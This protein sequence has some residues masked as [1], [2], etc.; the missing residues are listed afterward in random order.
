MWGDVKGSNQHWIV[1]QCTKIFFSLLITC[2]QILWWLKKILLHLFFWV[3]STYWKNIWIC[4][5]CFLF[6]FNN[7][8]WLMSYKMVEVELL[9]CIIQGEMSQILIFQKW[10][11]MR[12]GIN[13]YW[14]EIGLHRTWCD[15]KTANT[16]QWGCDLDWIL[17]QM[18]FWKIVWKGITKSYT[19]DILVD[20]RKMTNWDNLKK[21]GLNGKLQEPLKGGKASNL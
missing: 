2:H 1:L 6:L 4:K 3:S 15:W 13:N 16:V 19:N 17:H 12:R 18:I 11:P 20:E 21:F 5:I 8:F 14:F 9:I 7:L 10:R